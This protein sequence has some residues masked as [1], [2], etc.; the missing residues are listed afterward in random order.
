MTKHE[1]RRA[2]NPERLKAYSVENIQWVSHSEN[3]RRGATSKQ[4]KFNEN[5]ATRY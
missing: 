2:A 1:E 5:T 3:S 4:R